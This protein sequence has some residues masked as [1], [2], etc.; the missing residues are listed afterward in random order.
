MRDWNREFNEYYDSDEF[1]ACPESAHEIMLGMSSQIDYLVGKLMAVRDATALDGP[2][3][4][5]KDGEHWQSSTDDYEFP[6]P[7]E[8]ERCEA[9]I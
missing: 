7:Q 8:R 9:H 2:I 1:N 4:Y 5:H 6:D 3:S